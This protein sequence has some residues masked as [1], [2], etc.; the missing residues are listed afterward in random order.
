MKRNQTQQT[1]NNFFIVDPEIVIIDHVIDP[2]PGQEDDPSQGTVEADVTVAGLV[3]DQGI[4]KGLAVIG[5]DLKSPEKKENDREAEI[6]KEA[7]RAEVKIAKKKSE[8]N[9]NVVTS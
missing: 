9:N 3:V 6:R 2:V 8:G 4:A 1:V 7:K 5:Q